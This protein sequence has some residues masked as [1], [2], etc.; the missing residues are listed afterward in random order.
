MTK[1]RKSLTLHHSE[2]KQV[3]TRITP[4]AAR[5]L[6]IIAAKEKRSVSNKVALI[7]EEFV[8][9]EKKRKEKVPAAVE[10]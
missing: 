4:E 10:E 6:A 5:L 3:T 8:A 1:R 9:I 2:L 7:I